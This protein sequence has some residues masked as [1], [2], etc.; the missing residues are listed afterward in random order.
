M[1]FRDYLAVCTCPHGRWIE[2]EPDEM[3]EQTCAICEVRV[4]VVLTEKAFLRSMNAVARQSGFSE[5]FPD[6]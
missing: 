2:D 1:S 5:P 6:V 3:G 4:R